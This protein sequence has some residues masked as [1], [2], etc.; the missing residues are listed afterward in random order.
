MMIELGGSLKRDVR[1]PIY[2]TTSSE[3]L[4]FIPADGCGY[5]YYQLIQEVLE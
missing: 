2:F 1:K 3:L 4:G 5:R